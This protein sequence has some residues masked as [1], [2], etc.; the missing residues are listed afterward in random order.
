MK[1]RKEYTIGQSFALSL[2][3]P[4]LILATLLVSGAVLFTFASKYDSKPLLIAGIVLTGNL[5]IAYIIF[6]FIAFFKL[7]N[8]Y[9]NGLYKT[10]A[11]LL[12]GLKAN[13]PTNENFPETTIKDFT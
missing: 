12:R 9:Q 10:T 2:I 8:T 3:I 1:K 5:S 13:V 6:S 11:S 4:G 7:R